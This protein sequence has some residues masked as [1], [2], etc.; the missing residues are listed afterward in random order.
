L[1]NQSK[2]KQMPTSMATI[3]II[4]EYHPK[5]FIKMETTPR[6]E[7]AV[8]KLYKAFHESRLTAFDCRASAVGNLLGHGCRCRGGKGVLGNPV[9]SS[10]QFPNK[11][12]YSGVELGKI[13]DVFLSAHKDNFTMATKDQQFK[14]L[15]VVVEYLCELDG[16]P[17]V[18]DYTSLFE[19]ENDK[20]K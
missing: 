17:N 9:I 16:I 18:M 19:T 11:S 7:N 13:E 6:F 1:L 5:T 12:G 20:P 8:T 14:G 2:K 3:T 15:C 10:S 4:T